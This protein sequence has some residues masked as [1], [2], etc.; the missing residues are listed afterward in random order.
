ML[1]VELPLTPSSPNCLAWSADGEIAIAAGEDVHLLVKIGQN[2]SRHCST[3]WNLDT[4]SQ[5]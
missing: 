1:P 2:N 5:A 3:N 4:S